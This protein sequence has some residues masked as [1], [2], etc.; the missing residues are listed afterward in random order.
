MS[1]Y[2]LLNALTGAKLFAEDGELLA[3]LDYIHWKV[4]RGQM[5]AAEYLASV[6]NNASMDLLFVTGPEETHIKFSVTAGGACT[7][8][9]YE[10]TITSAN[11]TIVPTHNHRRSATNVASAQ[12]YRTPTVTTVGTAL[13]PGRYL[14]GGASQATR[15]GG[16]VRDEAELVLKPNSK[17]LLRVTN[18]SGGAVTVNPVISFYEHD[19]E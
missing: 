17:Y 15:I 5:F 7:V 1:D 3:V 10:D 6:N 12:L 11:G 8:Y 2:V 4:H 18:I 13:I 16:A 14:A 9:L 19:E